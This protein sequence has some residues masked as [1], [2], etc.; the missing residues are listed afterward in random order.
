MYRL[1][2]NAICAGVEMDILIISSLVE[3]IACKAF[4]LTIITDYSPVLI[5]SLFAPNPVIDRERAFLLL[6]ANAN[7]LGPCIDSYNSEKA[8]RIVPTD[9]N[10]TDLR[11]REAL[12]WNTAAVYLQL[13]NGSEGNVSLQLLVLSEICPTCRT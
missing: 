12:E 3:Q 4:A 2:A 10:W 13:E 9:L 5:P 6:W 1:V 11:K 7:T 8:S